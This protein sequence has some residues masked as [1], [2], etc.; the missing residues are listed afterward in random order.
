MQR[1]EIRGLSSGI[2]RPFTAII[3]DAA[4]IPRC[5]I[6]ATIGLFTIMFRVFGGRGGPVFR[7]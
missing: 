7:K 6:Q 4:R 2:L 1:S 3:F 5:C